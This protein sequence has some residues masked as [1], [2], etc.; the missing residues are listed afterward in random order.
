[1]NP[2]TLQNTIDICETFR[3][4]H[5]PE[6]EKRHCVY[7]KCHNQYIVMM[8][9]LPS[10]ADNEQRHDVVDSNYAKFRAA[11]LKVLLI[12]NICDVDD[13]PHRIENVFEGRS[14]YYI[15]G[16]TVTPHTFNTN[17]NRVCTGGIHYFKTIEVAYFYDKV[18]MNYTGACRWWHRNGTIKSTGEY[19]CGKKSGYWTRW[20]ISGGMLSYVKYIDGAIV[21]RKQRVLT[22]NNEE[23]MIESIFEKMIRLS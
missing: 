14:T 9:K 2:L 11:A 18:P 8:Q 15:V 17:I 22:N 4:T 20:G 1:M 3:T 6:C 16:E 12:M 21:K 23:R 5:H 19:V 7:K 13:R 10:T